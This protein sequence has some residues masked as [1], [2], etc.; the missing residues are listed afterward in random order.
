M[1]IPSLSWRQCGL[2]AFVI[3]LLFVSL[4]SSH[5]LN[6]ALRPD[7]NIY[8]SEATA[9]DT[10]Q[11][12]YPSVGPWLT[13]VKRQRLLLDTTIVAADGTPLHAIYVRAPQPNERRIALL[14][15]GYKD[16]AVRMF[17]LAKMY[18]QDLGYN[19]LIP[20]LR[21]HGQTPGEYVGMGWTIAKI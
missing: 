10:M 19:L 3:V 8:R 15:H 21:Y 1:R 17:H 16:S 14:V 20:D 11:R 2:L 7:D 18:H 12:L 13:A 5:L 6:H 4:V 9:L